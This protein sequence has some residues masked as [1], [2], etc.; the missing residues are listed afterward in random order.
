MS[1]YT[2]I[3]ED[4]PEEYQTSA[5]GE[6]KEGVP[7][8]YKH[9]ILIPLKTQHEMGCCSPKTTCLNVNGGYKIKLSSTERVFITDPTLT[10]KRVP[11]S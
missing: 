11:K 2:L 9:N 5:I 7:V 1:N 8:E 6:V 3:T 4:R 10:V